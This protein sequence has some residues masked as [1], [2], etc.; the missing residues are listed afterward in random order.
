MKKEVLIKTKVEGYIDP[1][2][3]FRCYYGDSG[4]SSVFIESG[5]FGSDSKSITV[6]VNKSL[7]VEKEGG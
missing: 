7:I 4:N 6:P 2:G 3:I 1:E 5:F